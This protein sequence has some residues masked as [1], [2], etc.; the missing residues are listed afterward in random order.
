MEL[1]FEKGEMN[2]E[3]ASGMGDGSLGIIE[4]F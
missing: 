1:D 3:R 4:L 2:E